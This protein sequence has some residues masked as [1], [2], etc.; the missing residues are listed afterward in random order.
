MAA[1]KDIMEE[2]EQER[3][4]EGEELVIG[5]G[6]DGGSDD[7]STITTAEETKKHRLV[8]TTNPNANC[9]AANN[10]DTSLSTAQEDA[11]RAIDQSVTDLIKVRERVQ[12]GTLY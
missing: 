7:G 3:V 5:V 11:L 4:E 8:S 10:S 6:D 1:R 9:S 12:H 2:D